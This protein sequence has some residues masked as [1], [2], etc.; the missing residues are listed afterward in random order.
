MRG[1]LLNHI[2]PG[3]GRAVVAVVSIG[4]IIAAAAGVAGAE[5]VECLK[6]DCT[7]GIGMARLPQDRLYIGQWRHGQPDGAGFLIYS[8]DQPMQRAVYEGMMRDGK[9]HGSGR[10]FFPDGTQ[11]AGEFQ[12]DRYE[13]YGVFSFPDG[14]SYQGT[15]RADQYDGYG[16]YTF[17]DG[18][19][20][21]GYWERGRFK[22]EL[23]LRE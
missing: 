14:S 15:F 8:P 23:R 9:R 6:G 17:P 11:Y 22:R 10:M 2:L 7:D 12:D 3:W 13:G 18:S 5:A 1:S 19:T 16:I 20:K 21:E 4:V